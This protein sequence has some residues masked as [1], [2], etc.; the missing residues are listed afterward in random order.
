MTK[1][2]AATDTF[3]EL[4]A[5]YAGLV[6]LAAAAFMHFEGQTFWD[7]VYWAATTATST[8]FGDI[9][10]KTNPGK[11][12]AVAL[13]HLSLLFIIP[14]IVVR[15]IERLNEDRDKFTHDEQILI[16][17]GIRN[18]ATRL[19]RIERLSGIESE[20]I[21]AAKEGQDVFGSGLFSACGK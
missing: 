7:S 19:E 13:M 18:I 21:E 11:V 2:Q 9:S 17:D 12:I 16:L 8:G 6:T 5:L 4:I 15:L 20:I 14:L 3:K 1:L 10:P